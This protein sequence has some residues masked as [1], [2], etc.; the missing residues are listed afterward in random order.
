MLARILVYFDAYFVMILQQKIMHFPAGTR[1]YISNDV[2]SQS[3]TLRRDVKFTNILLLI[4]QLVRG[5]L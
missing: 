1:T 2:T 3:V 4:F 5:R